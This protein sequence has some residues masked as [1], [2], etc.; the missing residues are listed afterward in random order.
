MQPD[1]ISTKPLKAATTAHSGKPAAGASVS[2]ADP[3]GSGPAEASKRA[4]GSQ[5]RGQFS[6][7]ALGEQLS[8][9]KSLEDRIGI[10]K[11]P[12]R[13][14]VIKVAFNKGD[15]TE[16]STSPRAEIKDRTK[17]Q[18]GQPYSFRFGMKREAN[19]DGTFFQVLDHNNAKPSPRAWLATK[20]GQYQLLSR[21]A[22]IATPPQRYTI[23]ESQGMPE[24]MSANGQIFR[25]TSNVVL[26]MAKSR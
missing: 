1:P 16:H 23:L 11:D 19:N 21:P 26:G 20:D 15:Y 24:E 2:N 7:N 17:L 14:D 4:G 13:G 18:E 5:A 9:Q 10:A 8:V 22:R 25:S 12:E 3:L 6:E